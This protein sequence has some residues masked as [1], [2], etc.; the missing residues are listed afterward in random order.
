MAFGTPPLVLATAAMVW[1]LDASPVVRPRLLSHA[2]SWA[3]WDRELPW[4]LPSA[5]QKLRGSCRWIGCRFLYAAMVLGTASGLCLKDGPI[6]NVLHTFV[7]MPFFICVWLAVIFCTASA[8]NSTVFGLLRFVVTAAIVK[9]MLVLLF[10]FMFA[11]EYI[12]NSLGLSPSLYAATE[13]AVL[14]LLAAWPLTWMEDA[15]GVRDPAA[16]SGPTEAPMV[17]T[18]I[19]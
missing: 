16:S 9:G 7:T 11:Y 17:R 19:V 1:I 3:P 15:R 13:Y 14:I 4:K 6:R 2:A 10:V 12:P 5:P 18:T 8:E